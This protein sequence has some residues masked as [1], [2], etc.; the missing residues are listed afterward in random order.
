M[1]RF[2]V[3]RLAL[4]P[5]SLFVVVTLSFGLLALIPGD[6]AYVIAGPFPSEEDVAAVQEALGLDE[7]VWVQYS[8]YLANVAQ[9]DLGR[10][11]YTNRPVVEDILRL[12]P[13]TIELIVPSILLAMIFGIGVGILAA[14]YGDQATGRVARGVTGV[15]Q[16]TP[17]FVMG[18]ALIYVFFYRAGLAPPPVGRTGLSEVILIRWTGFPLVDA[19]LTGEWAAMGTLLRHMVLP[20]LTIGIV[21]SAYFARITRA[22]MGAALQ[23]PQVE[24]ARANG[25]SE[26]RVIWYAFLDARTPI[27]TYSVILLAAMSGGVIIVETIFAWPGIGQWGLNSIVE[28]DIPAAQGFIVITG[29]ITLTLYILLDIVTKYLDPRVQYE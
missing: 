20:V 23:S 14:Y 16:S 26:R 24:F 11:L 17:D 2:L 5:V 19:V 10:S 18:L 27:I 4:I 15:I 28:L 22:T 7:P 12:A 21:Y 1:S 13:N 3:I 8:T 29:G 6:P 25:L 9:G